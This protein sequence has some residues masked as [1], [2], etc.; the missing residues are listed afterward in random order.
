MAFIHD[1]HGLNIPTINEL[2]TE[3]NSLAHNRTR[4]FGDSTVN[5]ALDSNLARVS[6]W[7]RQHSTVVVFEDLH[8]KAILLSII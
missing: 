3:C 2:Y 4:T 8:K 1:K 7:T 5:H 6:Q